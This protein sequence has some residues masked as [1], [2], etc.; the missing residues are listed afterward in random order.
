MEDKKILITIGRQFGSNGR[1]IGNAIGEK[2]GIKCYD[3]DLIK[4]TAKETGLWENLLDEMDEKHTNS[5]L[6]SVVMDPYAFAY[7]FDN[8]GYGMSLNQKAFM[9]TYNTIEKIAKEGSAV[10][11][12]RCADYVLRNVEDV[13]SVFLY[14]PMDMRVRTVM[15]RYDISEKRA[16]DQIQKEDK[17]RASYYNYYTSAKWGKMESYDLCIDTSILGPDKTAE[18][19]IDFAKSMG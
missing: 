12:G 1:I 14:A 2:L 4:R 9:A 17:A 5:F 19:I 7:S 10:F 13:L 18:Q 6:Y 3:K 8:Q 11:I 15:Q 16:R